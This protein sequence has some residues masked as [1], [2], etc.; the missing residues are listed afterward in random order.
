MGTP[1][2]EPWPRVV[3]GVWERE[4]YRGPLDVLHARE[5]ETNFTEPQKVEE[6]VS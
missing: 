1:E 2:G 4:C 6:G 5:A 3:T